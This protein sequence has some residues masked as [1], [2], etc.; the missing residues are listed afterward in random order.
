M[1]NDATGPFG[2]ADFIERIMSTPGAEDLIRESLNTQRAITNLRTAEAEKAI[3]EAAELKHAADSSR[4][5][6]FRNRTLD[7]VAPVLEETVEKALEVASR[8]HRLSNEP[9][10]FRFTSPG[11]SPISGLVLYDA[12]RGMSEEGTKIVSVSLGMSASMAGVLLQAGD[13]RIV[14]PNSWMLIHELSTMA[15][16]DAPIRLTERENETEF[17]EKLNSNLIDILSARS[18]LSSAEIRRKVK[19]GDWWVSADDAIK[20]GF[21]DRKGTGSGKV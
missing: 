11:G 14:G 15:N 5:S 10:T 8:W 16:H 20:Y 4:A 21:A 6:N 17:L 18:T 12:L 7:F 3:I 1:V 2:T 13:D 9:I 19:R